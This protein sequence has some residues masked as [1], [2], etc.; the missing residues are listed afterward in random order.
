[1]NILV[2][3]ATGMLGRVIVKDCLSNSFNVSTIGRSNPEIPEVDHIKYDFSNSSISQ[4]KSNKTFDFIIHCAA[5][6]DHSDCDKNIINCYEI[7]SFSVL[8]LRKS[9]PNVFFILISSDAVFN[10][11]CENRKFDGP[12]KALSNYG[13]SK[14]IAEKLSLLF[15]KSLVIRTTIIGFSDQKKSLCDWIVNS[16]EG[17]KNI[18]LFDDVLFNPISIYE[19]SKAIIFI[20]N[21]SHDYTSKI[22][23]MNN[24]EVIS[25]YKFGIRLAEVLELD[26]KYIEKGS[27]Q[28]FEKKGNRNFN[29][30]LTIELRDLEKILKYKPT[31]ERTI[32]TIRKHYEIN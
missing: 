16:L 10:D 1:M 23:H 18:K 11:N 6:T 2:S 9:F 8:A 22:I 31:L 13:V 30:Q 21:N 24:Q 4:I 5:N 15:N 26:P 29:Q 20:I 17:R 3:G 32:K 7:N 25:K 12:T 14:E 28:A 19:L 27:L